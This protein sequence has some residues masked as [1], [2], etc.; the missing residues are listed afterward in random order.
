MGGMCQGWGQ[1]V[2]S[3]GTRQWLQESG[4]AALVN[5]VHCGGVVRPEKEAGADLLRRGRSV[6]VPGSSGWVADRDSGPVNKVTQSEHGWRPR[7]P[8]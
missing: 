8:G 4:K 2:Q 6:G 3:Y 5:G 7:L 1:L